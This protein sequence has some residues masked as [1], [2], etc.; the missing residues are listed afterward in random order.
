MILTPSPS[1]FGVAVSKDGTIHF[2][3]DIQVDDLPPASSIGDFT[4]YEAWLATPQL[5]VVRNLGVIENGH[6]LHGT[7]EWNKFTVFVT[8][9]TPPIK[10]KWAGAVVLVGRSPSSLMQ[11]FAGHPFYNTGSAPF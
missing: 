1:P 9:E 6:V 8:A 2:D 10:P 5:D 3:L 4:T 7:A 11:S